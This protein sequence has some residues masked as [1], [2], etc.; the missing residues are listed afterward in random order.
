MA[1][2]QLRL[3]PAAAPSEI[4]QA[5]G[6]FLTAKSGKA[7]KTIQFY[8]LT[9]RQFRDYS[10]HAW[11]PTPE[12]INAYLSDCKSRKLTV[13][14]IDTY[15]RALRGWLT[16]CHKHGY[17]AD[18]PI[19]LAEK[20][21]HP[22]LIPRAPK[23]EILQRLFAFLEI[24]ANKGKGHFLDVRAL[25]I[26]SVALDT[27]IRIGELAALTLA[28][29]T[30]EKKRRSIFVAGAKTHQ[31]RNV[32]IDKR[33]AKDLRRWLKVRARLPLPPDLDALWIC[34]VRGEWKGVGAPGIRQAL[35]RRCRELDL[36]HITPHQ[37]RHAY[38]VMVLRKKG[39]GRLLDVQHQLGHQSLSTTS[40]YLR[41]DESERMR[42]HKD[43]SPRGDL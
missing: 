20:P 28:D 33:T 2:P 12:A 13:S 30:L 31:D 4:D 27:G 19:E 8:E 16:W 6:A 34:Y 23:V 22:K 15:F 14:T 17:L 42:R 21:P 32:V 35:A 25:A 37:F 39:E 43:H 1:R 24:A 5:T 7:R 18:N 3:I 10:G 41:I 38:A 9:L 29:V 36:P 26:W 40:R 11:P